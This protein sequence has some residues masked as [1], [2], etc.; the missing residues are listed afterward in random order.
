VEQRREPRIRADREVRITRIGVPGGECSG[1]LSNFSGRG[2][3][4]LLSSSIAPG[5]LIKVEWDHTMILGEVSFCRKSGEEYYVGVQLKHALYHTDELAALAQR[6][7]GEDAS[8]RPAPS[9]AAP[10]R[11]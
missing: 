7:R 8:S 5:S 6:L 1:R 10:A 4:L 11:R 3:G 2:A 9:F